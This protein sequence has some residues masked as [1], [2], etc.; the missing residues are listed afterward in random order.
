MIKIATILGARP[1]FIKAS[2]LSKL[3]KSRKD[4]KEIIIHTGQHYDF[5]MSNIFFKE[6]NIPKPN[7]NLG[8]RSNFHG[9]MTGEMLIKIEKLL[10]KI[11]PNFTIVYGDTNSTLAGALASSKLHI[12][13]V[14]IEAGLR[15]FNRKMPEEINRVL[16]DHCSTYF[17]VPS[18]LS[19]VQLLKENINN[20]NIFIVGDIM[21][22]LF[23]NYK[24]K[25]KN[26]SKK[27]KKK[28]PN[29]FI[30][31]TFHRAENIN[32][33]QKLKSIIENFS[34]LSRYI[35]IIFLMHPSTKKKLK[36]FKLFGKLKK[37]VNITKPQGYLETMGLLKN[38]NL[39][40]TD[41]G[42]MQKEAFYS[43]I[44]CLTLRDETEWP[45]TLRDG[46]NKLVNVKN[47]SIYKN[48]IKLLN[49]TNLK[50][51]ASKVKM[52]YGAGNASQLIIKKLKI[53]SRNNKSK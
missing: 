52:I 21:F 38:S 34:G 26:I 45:E 22:D 10:L 29:Q 20:K 27:I 2:I 7:Y 53:L 19:K 39:L 15:S 6:L 28:Y 14:H 49:L 23:L 24:N 43:K 4:F 3:F 42:G 33:I 8:I 1:Q 30:L 37:I 13:V 44:P 5:E 31:T 40:I 47:K 9:E 51:N 41:S 50:N 32:S 16:T 17:F 35:K 11:K 48:A 25:I 46:S 18:K 36:K 12:P